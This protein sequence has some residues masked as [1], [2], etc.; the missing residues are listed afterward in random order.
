MAELIL[1]SL[2]I[3]A[4]VTVRVED[5]PGVT[6]EETRLVSEALAAA[7]Q[8]RTGATHALDLARDYP[9]DREDRCL[10]EIRARTGAE[11]VVLVKLL[12]AL[13]KI[14]LLAEAVNLGSGSRRNAQADL[15]REQEG[16]KAPLAGVA[17]I[18]FPG[19]IQQTI[20]PRAKAAP[21]PA[22][23]P[24][25]SPETQRPQEGTTPA[26]LVAQG[27]APAAESDPTPWIVLGTSIGV[28]AGGTVLG[29]L[30]Q[31]ARDSLESPEYL[32]LS[33]GEVSSRT[34]LA[35]NG[36]LGANILWGLGAIG[37]GTSV[38]MLSGVL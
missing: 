1:A 4:S 28:L 21:P 8:E 23:A 30:A 29:I 31:D 18:L 13:T 10:E 9:C 25:A 26:E 34:D 27:P 3:T 35:T 16:W 5:A 32:T 33:P 15:P 7:I 36:G 19:G 38:L 14:R 37:L 11:E 12:G 20:S 2:L 24:P 17:L 6:P 22:T